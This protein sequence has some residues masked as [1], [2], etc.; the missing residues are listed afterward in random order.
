MCVRHVSETQC[1]SCMDEM[2]PITLTLTKISF[3]CIAII[4]PAQQIT[5]LDH[6]QIITM[7]TLYSRVGAMRKNFTY[8]A[9][10]M[11]NAFL[12]LLC[13]NYADIIG[14]GLLII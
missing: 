5:T 6:V 7:R 8:S 12:Y 9:G 10:I 2:L 13:S 1:I 14:A 4:S 11:F 3:Y